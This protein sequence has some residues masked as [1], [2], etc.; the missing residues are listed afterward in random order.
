MTH[1]RFS[2]EVRYS[3]PD[4][5]GSFTGMAVTFNVVDNYRSTFDRRAFESAPQRLPL[6]WSHDPSQVVGS[7]RSIIAT[8]EGLQIAGKLNL[9]VAKARE[10]R[11]MLLAGDIRGLSIGFRTLKDERRSN[12]VRHILKADLKEI[13]FV[14][15]PAVPGSQVTNVRSGN[16][17]AV[18]FVNECRITA[19]AISKGK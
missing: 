4:E 15:V 14:A 13:S 1:D 5:D 12:G 16:V 18:A 11:S 2:F 3:S 10:V 19:R 17:S 8:P 9:D 7:T 6:F